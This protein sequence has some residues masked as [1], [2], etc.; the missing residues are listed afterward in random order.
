M[1]KNLKKQY[2]NSKVQFAFNEYPP[3]VNVVVDNVKTKLEWAYPGRERGEKREEERGYKAYFH[4]LSKVLESKD[5]ILKLIDSTRH[6]KK[7]ISTLLSIEIIFAVRQIR[8]EY[9]LRGVPFRNFIDGKI[10]NFL[11]NPSLTFTLARSKAPA[12]KK[13]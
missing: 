12:R 4:I 6:N 1:K 13:Q 11:D 9:V 10:Q 8:S 3:P 7:F 5:G 2:R